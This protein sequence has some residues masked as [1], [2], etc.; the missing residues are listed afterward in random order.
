MS[1]IP[2]QPFIPP[3]IP[4]IV[5]APVRRTR[6]RSHA[7]RAVECRAP[8]SLARGSHG[9]DPPALRSL[10][11]AR[12]AS[13]FQGCRRHAR[14]VR[15]L[16][17]RMGEVGGVAQGLPPCCLLGHGNGARRSDVAVVWLRLARA[18]RN[19]PFSG[20]K[21]WGHDCPSHTPQG[22]HEQPRQAGVH[23]SQIEHVV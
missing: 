14:R 18:D 21:P 2:V 10:S 12:P 17:G 22:R 23:A 1:V 13:R 6:N 4:P 19:P 9:S 11:P 20:G 5:Q 15:T 16:R 3:I 7:Q 8:P